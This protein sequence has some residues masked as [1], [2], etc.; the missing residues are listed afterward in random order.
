MHIVIPDALL[1]I[2][3]LLFIAAFA[4]LVLGETFCESSKKWIRSL[5]NALVNII[6]V[7]AVIGLILTAVSTISD[8]AIVR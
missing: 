4:L 2:G 5:G 7:L 1:N 6:I 3:I 8:F